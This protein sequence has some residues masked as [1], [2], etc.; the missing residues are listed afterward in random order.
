MPA[1]LTSWYGT[2]AGVAG[3]GGRG[4]TAKAILESG[5]GGRKCFE[6]WSD[7]RV[8]GQMPELRSDGQAGGLS[9]LGKE[10]C[11]NFSRS[12]WYLAA[13]GWSM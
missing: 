7:W 2:E 11:T 8:R 12:A 9:Y 3:W 13:E 5:L 4:K 6:C 1:P 10:A